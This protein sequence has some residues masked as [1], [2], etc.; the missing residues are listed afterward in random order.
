MESFVGGS[1][2]IPPKPEARSLQINQNC[3]LINTGALHKAQQNIM[4]GVIVTHIL[5]YIFQSMRRQY[6]HVIS[7]PTDLMSNSSKSWNSTHTPFFQKCQ[8]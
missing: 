4:S 2:A 6:K 5:T 7:T 3:H 1:G 8:I